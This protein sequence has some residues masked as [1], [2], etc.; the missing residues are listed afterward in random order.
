[1]IERDFSM[2]R[3]I[4]QLVYRLLG[5]SRRDII[6]DITDEL[7]QEKEELTEL[8]SSLKDQLA[9]LREGTQGLRAI[10]DRQESIWR[11][12]VRRE[13][14]LHIHMDMA[15]RDMQII[16]SQM[17]IPGNPFDQEKQF[18]LQT[19]AP[20]AYESPD[21]LHPWGTKND[22]TRAPFFIKKCE[23][24]YFQRKDGFVLQTLAA[25][26]AGLYWMRC[27][28]DIGPLGWRAAIILAKANVQNGGFCETICL[29]V[30]LRNRILFGI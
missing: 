5:D 20:V 26:E 30:I 21:H 22:N 23:S 25:P 17:S 11:D 6:G 9:Q 16:L 19:D 14:Q 7:R 18:V 15:A 28:G 8:I 4:K 3:W 12:F 24:L 2:K 29:H 10:A 27:S 1:M 13:Q